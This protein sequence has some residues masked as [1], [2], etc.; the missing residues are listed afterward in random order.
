M[1]MSRH[2]H[3]FAADMIAAASGG[4]EN[5]FLQNFF[6]ADFPDGLFF[7]CAPPLFFKISTSVHHFETVKRPCAFTH[8][9]R[10]KMSIA[11]Q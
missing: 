5:F 6:P 7:L 4:T 1:F 11:R 3:C 9:K 8:S 2:Q 10:Q